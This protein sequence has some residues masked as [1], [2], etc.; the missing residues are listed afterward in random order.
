M[1]YMKGTCIHSVQMICFRLLV[2][3]ADCVGDL[4]EN[5]HLPGIA[6]L[7]AQEE[8]VLEIKSSMLILPCSSLKETLFITLFFAFFSCH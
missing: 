2:S 8:P 1:V 6:G 4:H 3:K 7:T 5:K